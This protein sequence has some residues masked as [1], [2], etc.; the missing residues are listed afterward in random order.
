M[1]AREA[2][3]ARYL[4]LAGRPTRMLESAI[5]SDGAII[6]VGDA[7]EFAPGRTTIV[8]RIEQ[9]P[10]GTSKAYEEPILWVANAM[11]NG[12]YANQVRKAV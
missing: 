12:V 11:V 7:V 4:R 6:Q 1:S 2:K 8:T 3:Q 5:G 9:E 10:S